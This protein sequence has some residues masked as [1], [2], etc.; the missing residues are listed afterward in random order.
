[1]YC[2]HQSLK[3]SNSPFGLG[4]GRIQDEEEIECQSF[5]CD[6]EKT[7][8]KIKGRKEEPK[9]VNYLI[10]RFILLSRIS[11]AARNRSLQQ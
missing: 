5:R 1:M 8:C 11:V 10:D 6:A 2:R 9:V 7:G 4:Q 3:T